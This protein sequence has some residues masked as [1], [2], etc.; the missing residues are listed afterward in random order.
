MKQSRRA[1]LIESTINTCSGFIFGLIGQIVFLPLLGVEIHLAQNL[2]FA[3]LMTGVSVG[4]G[5]IVRR[6]AEAW[7]LRIPITPA[8]IAVAA[9]RERQK[10]IEGYGIE[11]D[12]CHAP[13]ELERA[14]AAYAFSASFRMPLQRAAFKHGKNLDDGTRTF[15]KI[16]WPWRWDEFIPDPDKPRRDQVRSAALMLAAIEKGDRRPRSK[17]AML[18]ATHLPRPRVPGADAIDRQNDGPTRSVGDDPIRA[19]LEKHTKPALG[20]S[21]DAKALYDAYQAATGRGA[22]S[23][24]LFTLALQERGFERSRG[25]ICRWQGLKLVRSL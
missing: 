13:G 21:V 20:E 12:D 24:R 2:I 1:S 11:H 18:P 19:F 4:R 10:N 16:L 9:E 5:F 25:Q 6:I 7:H 3:G 23:A 22:L 17:S 15:L 8:L 14:A